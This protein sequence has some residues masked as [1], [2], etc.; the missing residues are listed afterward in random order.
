MLPST[1]RNIVLDGGATIRGWAAY[2][3][4]TG[5][6]P[7]FSIAIHLLNWVVIISGFVF[8]L[9][10]SGEYHWSQWSF[11]GVFVSVGLPYAAFWWWAKNRVKLNQIR[12]G[13]R[14]A[15]K[16]KACGEP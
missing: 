4:Q 13:K 7:W 9:W 8:L 12:N 11:A 3:Y 16:T 15:K 2:K 5:R 6:L 14:L 1:L 10:C